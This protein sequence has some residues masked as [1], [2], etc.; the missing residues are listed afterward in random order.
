[1]PFLMY[2]SVPPLV[3]IRSSA[4]SLNYPSWKP[5]APVNL[6]LSSQTRMCCVSISVW[7]LNGNSQEASTQRDPFRFSS[8]SFSSYR[9]YFIQCTCLV[10]MLMLLLSHQHFGGLGVS[11][12][13]CDFC[14]PV[15]IHPVY[16]VSPCS[17]SWF[18][19]YDIL[20]L[21]DVV[22]SISQRISSD[23]S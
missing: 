1:M 2:L 22:N 5:Q 14:K 8:S 15:I 16:M 10:I 20:D 18:W 17:F 23:A 6:N 11:P 4:S 21:L 3:L 19:F 9:P 12:S 13:F 7:S